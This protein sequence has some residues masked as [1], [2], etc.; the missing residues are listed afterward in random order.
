MREIVGAVTVNQNNVGRPRAII[1]DEQ[2]DGRWL[3]CPLR[4]QLSAHLQG[5][6]HY[7]PLRV[8]GVTGDNRLSHDQ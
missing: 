8:L 4:Q 5:A 3:I 7:L 6:G 2:Q 1:I